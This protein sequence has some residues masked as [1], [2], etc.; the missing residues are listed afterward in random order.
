LD[1]ISSFGGTGLGVVR[2]FS[3]LA[4]GQVAASRI[5]TLVTIGAAT[6]LLGGCAAVWGSTYTIESENPNEVRI[7]YD[8]SLT[9]SGH[10]AA[11]ANQSCGHYGKVAVARAQ[12][13]NA[14]LL[15]HAIFACDTSTEAARDSS[16]ALRD[17]V[18]EYD[19]PPIARQPVSTFTPDP[20]IYVLHTQPP[21]AP[22]AVPVPNL[23][24]VYYPPA[25]P[26]QSTP[27]DR[28]RDCAQ[29]SSCT[30]VF[31]PGPW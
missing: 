13:M 9:N 27:A 25:P 31:S 11:V 2:V 10:I 26:P 1:V 28:L 3:S 21:P 7:V 14:W 22:P 24:S 8:P 20:S 4:I 12:R 18:F 19:P 6:F 15:M 5:R 17:P 30:G 23:G 29:T 16:I